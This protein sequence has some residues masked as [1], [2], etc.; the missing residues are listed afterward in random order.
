M[1]VLHV[2]PGKEQDVIRETRWFCTIK[3]IAPKKKVRIRKGGV[4]H[5]SEEVIFPGYV[6]IDMKKLPPWEFHRLRE[7]SGVINILDRYKP[8]TE[9]DAQRIR[10]FNSAF[11]N[12][13]GKISEGQ[14]VITS[15]EF[16]FIDYSIVKFNRRNQTVVL[17][18]LFN[19]ELYR[20]KTSV[21]IN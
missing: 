10:A 11:I 16:A 8:L 19:G 21:E 14:L 13:K 1:F 3:A 12:L 2:L 5:E 7:I 20:V 18:F 4:W 6:F 9:E 17:E 15:S